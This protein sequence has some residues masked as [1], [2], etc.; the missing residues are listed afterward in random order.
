[1]FLKQFLENFERFLPKSLFLKPFKILFLDN[2]NVKKISE[3]KRQP[4]GKFDK[5]SNVFNGCRIF[6]FF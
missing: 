4:I 5:F 2:L 6:N 3:P 1:M